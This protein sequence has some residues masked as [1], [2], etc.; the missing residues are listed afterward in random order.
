[1]QTGFFLF[2]LVQFLYLPVYGHVGVTF[3][4]NTDLKT[5]MEKLEELQTTV[6]LQSDRISQL[7]KQNRNLERLIATDLHNNDNK[8]EERISILEKQYLC[9]E[10]RLKKQS[11]NITSV[12]TLERTTM[13]KMSGLLSRQN[14]QEKLYRNL[15]DR[16]QNLMHSQ[17]EK[18][19]FAKALTQHKESLI[20][21]ERL[22]T[23]VTTT[24]SLSNIVAF[25]AYFSK[26]VLSPGL[27]HI[28]TFDNVIT[29]TGNAYHSH[30]GTFIAPRSGL[31]V[32]T[33]TIRIYGTSYHSTELMVNDN[34]VGSTYLNPVNTID[35]SVTG[36]VV[37]HV[38]QG[39]DVLVRTR[40]SYNN[41]HINS[42]IVGKSSFAGWA[43]V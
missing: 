17:E 15:K 42:D 40:D 10:E 41:G 33:W 20:R 21:K 11:K 3:S 18:S 9:L 24:A 13:K 26:N 25:Y 35:G 23:P 39:D 14:V 29:N 7:E 31:Y 4:T 12:K 43:L 28:L 19:F 34:A 30:A 16:L 6:H 37:V 32:F 2:I 8:H 27:H 36:T 38:D 1:M 5:V 22:L